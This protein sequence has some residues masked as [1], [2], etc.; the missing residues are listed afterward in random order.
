[1]AVTPKPELLVLQGHIH[2]FKQKRGP[3]LVTLN[4]VIVE[5]P[6]E[7]VVVLNFITANNQ[8]LVMAA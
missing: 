4:W 1:M 5:P 3:R 7:V 8:Q 2:R 6:Q